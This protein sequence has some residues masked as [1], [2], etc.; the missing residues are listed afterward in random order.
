[1]RPIEAV[2]LNE[3]I[4]AGG[5]CALEGSFVLECAATPCSTKRFLRATTAVEKNSNGA[6]RGYVVALLESIGRKTALNGSF[7]RGENNSPA[8]SNAAMTPSLC[9]RRRLRFRLVI[10]DACGV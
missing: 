10:G 1:V 7:S 3:T 6:Q 5:F 2:E 8:A 9:L 4:V